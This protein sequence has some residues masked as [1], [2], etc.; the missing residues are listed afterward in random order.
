MEFLKRLGL[1]LPVIQAPM[2][3]VA[4]PALAAAVSNAGGLG[5]IGV[6]ATDADGARAMIEEL[7]ALTDASFNVNVFV[8][9]DPTPDPSRSAAWCTAMRPLFR[10]FGAEPPGNLR[11]IYDSFSQDQAKLQT[12][13]DL[14][15]PVVSFHFGL[16]QQQAIAA[17]KATGC[18]LLATATSLEEARALEQA[19]MDAIVAQGY[20]AGGHRGIFDPHSR[21]ERL[22]TLTLTRLLVTNT[23]LPV[24]SAGG[25]M[26]GAGIRAALDM[27]AVAAQLGTAF[28]ACPE[29]AAGDAYIEALQNAGDAGTVMTPAI[30]GRPARCL[31]NRL[32]EWAKTEAAPVPDYP[33]A[34]D[35]AKA[36]DTAARASGEYGFGAQWAG[37]GA[38][39]IRR[40]SAADLVERLRQEIGEMPAGRV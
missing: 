25:I 30:S 11:V 32:T 40:M 31:T 4:T 34:Y 33:M 23:A 6:G 24:I 17:L 19:G 35:A 20:E 38:P 22:S 1:S 13:L 3:G 36:L 27:G 15:P 9:S 37:Q 7:Q 39:L 12:L 8:H 21:D 10:R 28:I 14:A 29:S 2:A 5:S 26:D 18:L 16:P